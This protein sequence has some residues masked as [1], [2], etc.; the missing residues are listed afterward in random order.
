MDPD[1]AVEGGLDGERERG[2]LR[3]PGQFHLQVG[4]GARQEV[5]GPVG[6]DSRARHRRLLPADGA[7]L[8]GRVQGAGVEFEAVGEPP[9]R[10]LGGGDRLVGADLGGAQ[11]VARRGEAARQLSGGAKRVASGQD[12]RDLGLP[13]DRGGPPRRPPAHLPVVGQVPRADAVEV[14]GIGVDVRVEPDQ[15]RVSHGAVGEPDDVDRGGE[16]PAPNPRQGR[17]RRHRRSGGVRGGRRDGER[18]PEQRRG[19]GGRLE[20]GGHAVSPW[21]GLSATGENAQGTTR[22]VGGTSVRHSTTTTDQSGRNEARHLIRTHAAIVPAADKP[23]RGGISHAG[24]SALATAVWQRAVSAATLTTC[25]I[26][27]ARVPRCRP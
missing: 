24:T 10:R 8:H 4:R 16:R 6:A 26:T 21:I 25:V 23:R 5:N 14:E 27:A 18:T 11:V 2:D 20:Q 13:A 7:E 19:Y 1:A 22:R 17:D 9:D 15:V 12:A 3:G